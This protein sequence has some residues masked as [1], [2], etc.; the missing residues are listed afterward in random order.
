MRL[1]KTSTGTDRWGR[2]REEEGTRSDVPGREN[3][4]V[5]DVPP[6]Y[7]DAIKV[8][9]DPGRTAGG[10]ELVDLI[11]RLDIE[12][13]DIDVRK[14]V[15]HQTDKQ[16]RLILAQT[17][18]PV[19]SSQRNQVCEI[20]FLY[21]QQLKDGRV[22]RRVGYRAPILQVLP[23][24]Q[25]A[26]RLADAVIVV[27]GPQKLRPS[28]VR[29][30]YRVE[31]PADLGL[32]LFLMPERLE[33]RLAD[34]SAGGVGLYHPWGADLPVNTRLDLLLTLGGFALRLPARVIRS[35]G[36]SMGRGPTP[37]VA[38]A[39]MDMDTHTRRQL[40]QLVTDVSRLN[41]AR[42]SGVGL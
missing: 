30:F 8:A 16:G 1:G 24:F 40:L 25:L 3:L 27:P 39:F 21:H 42:R 31:P 29:L 18:P 7:A 6:A 5:P 28:S 14:S 34:L 36:R 26:D 37:P 4:V 2:R 23:N 10:Y 33:V 38:A 22:W 17:S 9:M 32:K 11:L 19:L 20:T 15:L 13:D 12:K 41:L 35:G